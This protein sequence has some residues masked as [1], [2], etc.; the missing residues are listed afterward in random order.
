MPPT[1]SPGGLSAAAR[2][3]AYEQERGNAADRLYNAA[4][5]KAAKAFLCHNPLCSYCDLDGIVT[6]ATLVDHFWPHRGDRELFWRREFWVPSCASCH[7][8]M[9]QAIERAG[10]KA[11][12]DLAARLDISRPPGGIKSLAPFG[13]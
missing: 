13:R 10:W 3:R 2:Q 7:S 1:F 8:G 11:M 6:A 12:E 5:A 4:W 9:K